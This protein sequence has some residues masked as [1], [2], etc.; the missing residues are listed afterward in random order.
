MI[1]TS[2]KKI[3]FFLIVFLYP[4]IRVMIKTER[5]K[6]KEEKLRLKKQKQS[7]KVTDLAKSWNPL[8]IRG[9]KQKRLSF[10][11]DKHSNFINCK[12]K[13]FNMGKYKG[14][15]IKYVPLSY[16]SWVRKN[17]ELNETELNLLKTIK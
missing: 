14:V 13:Y 8:P 9:Q 15:D 2:K 16:I 17:I 4:N 3:R 1:N 5:V 7:Q 12:H 6:T 10:T 11:I